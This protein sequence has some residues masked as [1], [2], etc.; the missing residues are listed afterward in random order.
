MRT[1][2]PKLHFALPQQKVVKSRKAERGNPIDLRQV[3]RALRFGRNALCFIL[4]IEGQNS[5]T[6]DQ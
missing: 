6:V 4:L 2:D 5:I 1:F 3:G